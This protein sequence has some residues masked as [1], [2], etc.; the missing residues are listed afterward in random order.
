MK[1]KLKDPKPKD[2]REVLAKLKPGQYL[3]DMSFLEQ[4]EL[5]AETDAKLADM[6][7]T[8]IYPMIKKNM[9]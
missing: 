3:A 2:L 6:L 1:K 9:L 5:K 8:K 7:K 4:M